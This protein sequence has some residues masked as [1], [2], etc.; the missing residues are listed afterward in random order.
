MRKKLIFHLCFTRFLQHA[1][2]SRPIF[3]S[4]IFILFLLKRPFQKKKG[5]NY[6]PDWK[7]VE[8]PCKGLILSVCHIQMKESE[9]QKIYAP[10]DAKRGKKCLD[11]T[12]VCLCLHL[13]DLCLFFTPL[14]ANRR[15]QDHVLK[16]QLY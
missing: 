8:Q 5:K 11:N 9:R 16:S 15:H 7:K 2:C 4:C 12:F 6:V 3:R 14:L 1:S 13:L 10:T